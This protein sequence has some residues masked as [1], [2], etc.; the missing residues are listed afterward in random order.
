[1][2]TDFVTMSIRVSSLVDVGIPRW[3]SPFAADVFAIPTHMTVQERLALLQLCLD[4]P[5]GFTA[6][7]IGSYLGA[8]TAFLAMAA[9]RRNGHVHAV[10]TW[11]NHGMGAEGEWDTWNEFRANTA[12]F[13]HYIT[14][15]RG[16]SLEIAK[17]GLIP[18]DALFIDGDH[19]YE[20]V[21]A[22]LEAWLPSLR[23]G[24]T[25]AMHDFDQEG[26]RRA[27]AETAGVDP[28]RPL[29]LVDRLMIYAWSAT[30]TNPIVRARS[31][32]SSLVR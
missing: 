20:S 22:D 25:L 26:V 16:R 3:M 19:K 23:D 11:E 30:T 15:H 27:F 24:G 8:S 10:D 18:C 13:A 29:Q 31:D 7:E 5:E 21:K 32:I 4:R 1:M 17:Q 14:A 12:P 6:L 2:A 9:L 28:A